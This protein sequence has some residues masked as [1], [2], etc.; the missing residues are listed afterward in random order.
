MP[1]EADRSDSTQF[2][3]IARQ[4]YDARTTVVRVIITT[5]WRLNS[6]DSRFFAIFCRDL[7]LSIRL[8]CS[9]RT[10]VNV[11]MTKMYA[12]GYV[13]QICVREEYILE[14]QQP[15]SPHFVSVE[16]FMQII[17]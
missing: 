2:V 7:P 12:L 10:K 17:M 9:R 6:Y 14:Y 1:I 13:T 11:D 5:V 16:I 15:I 4:P 3:E 8:C